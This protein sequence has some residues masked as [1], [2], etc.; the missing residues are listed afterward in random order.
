MLYQDQISYLKMAYD[1]ARKEST[2]PSTQN[3]AILLTKNGEILS[4][5]NHFPKGVLDLPERWERPIKYNYVE[6]AERN[7]ILKACREGICTNGAIMFCPWFS[8]SDCSR[9]IIQAGITEVIG[10]DFLM[11]DE[12][13]ELVKRWKDSVSIGLSMLTESGVKYSYINEKLD[14]EPILKD[15]K[16]F[17][18]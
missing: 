15:G 7:V 16:L 8:C 4:G 18:P 3:G 10:H 14:V 11:N 13:N 6:H 9:A 2:D 5:A 17:Y 12:N 1:V